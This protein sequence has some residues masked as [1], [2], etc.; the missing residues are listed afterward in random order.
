MQ[1]QA[2]A[3]RVGDRD[4]AVRR[5]AGAARVELEHPRQQGRAELAAQMVPLLR[6]VDAVADE[7]PPAGSAAA[8]IP[9]AA[10]SSRPAAVSR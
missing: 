2:L 10:S 9:N 8:S 4:R 7:R 6:P 1:A 5:G 3:A